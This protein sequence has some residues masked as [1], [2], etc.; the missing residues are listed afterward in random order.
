MTVPTT[1]A[2]LPSKVQLLIGSSLHPHTL[3]I[4][5][6]VSKAWQTLFNPLLWRRVQE[7]RLTWDG[8]PTNLDVS[9]ENCFVTC[10]TEGALLKNG[11]LV[12]FLK[13]D[14]DNDH[15]LAQLL[16]Y[17]P[18]NY[19]RLHSAEFGDIQGHD[20]L[21]AEF[22]NRG[23]AGWRT[24]CFRMYEMDEFVFFGTRSA[25]AILKHAETLEVL[26]IGHAPFLKSKYI[27][28]L[29][30]SAPN[31]K[32]LYLLGY[33]RLMDGPDTTLNAYDAASSEW[34]CTNLEVFGCHI[35]GIPRPDITRD[36]AGYPPEEFTIEG[37][38]EES[39]ALQRR[40]YTQLGR[41]TKLRELTLGSPYTDGEEADIELRRNMPF[42]HFDCLA[43]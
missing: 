15:F 30:S 23:K 32:T 27:Q 19:P 13:L 7:S 1:F 40:V 25:R 42:R 21:I 41:L 37:T 22:I 12:E 26:R 24:L 33:E 39:I 18:K 5:V 6:R 43:L 38:R 28:R 8:K 2:N 36:I 3:S 10:L 17:T 11:H 14:S 4:C 35:G 20:E 16:E 34:V 31:L 9:W 29:L